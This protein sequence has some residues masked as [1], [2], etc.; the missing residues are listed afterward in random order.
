MKLARPPVTPLMAVLEDND[1]STRRAAAGLLVEPYKS[2]WTRLTSISYWLNAA[3]YPHTTTIRS[4]TLPRD[5]MSTVVDTKTAPRMQ[6][7][8]S[9][10][11]FERDCELAGL[12]VLTPVGKVAANRTPKIEVNLVSY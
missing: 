8:A 7:T 12:S 1:G 3:A 11:P 10:S 6:I 9:V 2:G 5:N 4:T